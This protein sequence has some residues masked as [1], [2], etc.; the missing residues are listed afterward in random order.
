MPPRKP[1]KITITEEYILKM[2]KDGLPAVT[3][4]EVKEKVLN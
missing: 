3:Q 1:E 4:K 2:I